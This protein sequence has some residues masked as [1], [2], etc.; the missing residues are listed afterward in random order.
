[1][2][3]EQTLES[4]LA[5]VQPTPSVR[6]IATT[7]W[8]KF[9]A[10]CQA[11]GIQ[12]LNQLRPKHLEGFQKSLMWEPNARGEYYKANTV[13]QFLRRV[14]QVLRW[15][16]DSQ[17]LK[18]DPTVCLL[19]PRP[20]QPAK[21]LLTWQELQAVFAAPDRTRPEGLRDAVV[22]ALL[23]ETNLKLTGVLALSEGEESG[24]ELETNTVQL[25]QKYVQE[26]RPLLLPRLGENALLLNLEGGR[27]SHQSAMIRMRLLGKMAGL[28]GFTSRLLRRSY[29]AHLERENQSR[30]SSLT[31]I[32]N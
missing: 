5:Q 30:H 15:A 26:G 14:R 23:A 4:Y 11:E 19:L 22:L 17:K 2:T 13:D 7:S 27:L 9:V 28:K 10:Y 31:E 25:V 18:Q 8:P 6:E 12:E 1:M 29:R 32:L 24:L 21:A 20:P 16:A 3:I